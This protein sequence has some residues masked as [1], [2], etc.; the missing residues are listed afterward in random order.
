MSQAERLR[1]VPA[2]SR[3]DQIGEAEWNMRVE[4]A[5]CYRLAA[6]EGW[7]DMIWTHISAAVPGSRQEFLLNPFG[8]GFDEVTASNLVKIDLAGNVIVGDHEVNKAGYIIH[9][10]IHEHRHDIK[11]VMHL[12]SESG[13]A[14]SMLEHGLLP[15][16]QHAMRFHNRIAYHDYEG[17]VL[18][19]DEKTRLL[20]NLGKHRVMILRNHGFLT[21]GRSIGEAF[22]L[23]YY[24]EK[25]ARAQLT[26]LAACA[27]GGRIVNP[28]DTVAERTALQ[29]N[30]DQRDSSALEWAQLLRSLDRDDLSYKT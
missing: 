12:H 25:A 28:D 22:V 30:D 7:T 4:L 6:R 19:A 1:P 2:K 14:L 13:M 8:L 26:A 27:G 23:M 10:V 5:A 24:L 9:S 29:F 3:R 11:C 15:L 16:T 17:I 20:A 21:T 18:D